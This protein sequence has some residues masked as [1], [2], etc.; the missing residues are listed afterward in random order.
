[1]EVIS[2]RTSSNPN[3]NYVDFAGR[4]RRYIELLEAWFD[5]PDDPDD[6]SGE[7]KRLLA[8]C[9]STFKLLRYLTPYAIETLAGTLSDAVERADYEDALTLAEILLDEDRGDP[10]G[11]V[12]EWTTSAVR[13]VYRHEPAPRVGD[14]FN[15]FVYAYNKHAGT[16]GRVRCA[17]PVAADKVDRFVDEL[18]GLLSAHAGLMVDRGVEHVDIPLGRFTIETGTGFVGALFAYITHNQAE[19]AY[20]YP[21]D[22]S[23]V[24]T[25]NYKGG[26]ATVPFITFAPQSQDVTYVPLWHVAA[27]VR[28]DFFT[29]LAHFTGRVED[30]EISADTLQTK[31]IDYEYAAAATY[32]REL[33]KAHRGEGAPRA[34]V[35]A[36]DRAYLCEYGWERTVFKHASDS[37]F[38]YEQG[39]VLYLF[40]ASSLS[41][42]KFG[43]YAIQTV[44]VLDQVEEVIPCV[45]QQDYFGAT[46]HFGTTADGRAP[47]FEVDQVG[48]DRSKTPFVCYVLDEICAYMQGP[49]YSPS[50]V[51][52]RTV[53]KR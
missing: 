7:L 4:R 5:G 24:Y 3:F 9:A 17:F 18:P 40:V 27:P 28:L 22:H 50:L 6:I 20:L 16:R 19:Y 32:G 14:A 30:V 13:E 15:K 31:T 35:F 26:G 21:N 1:M 45:L 44:S 8:P 41:F 47:L 29:E 48:W 51:I 10:V 38:G 12:V 39:G 11:R 46:A 34:L 43:D 49:D 53:A 25:T 42:V 33:P 52:N 23:V 37:I 2:M 36:W